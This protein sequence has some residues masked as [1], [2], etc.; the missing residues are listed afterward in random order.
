M[1]VWGKAKVQLLPNVYQKSHQEIL[2]AVMQ[3]LLNEILA[4]VFQMFINFGLTQILL[5]LDHN[6]QFL[7]RYLNLVEQNWNEPATV[8]QHLL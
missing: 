8:D 7:W 5:W 2:W 3:I 1:E 6:Q 4:E